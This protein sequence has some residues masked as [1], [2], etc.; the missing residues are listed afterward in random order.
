MSLYFYKPV[1]AIISFSPLHTSLIETIHARKEKD[2]LGR[3]ETLAAN[4]PLGIMG[5]PTT[6]LTRDV[7]AG[8]LFRAFRPAQ[9][10]QSFET[11][12]CPRN[13][14]DMLRTVCVSYGHSEPAQ[15]TT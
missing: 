3:G 6:Y 5:S 12:T 11:T 4:A 2:F 13:K 15:D 7:L 1:L 10:P 14:A 8:R 9:S